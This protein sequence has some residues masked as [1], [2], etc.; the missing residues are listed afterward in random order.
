MTHRSP[1]PT[2]RLETNAIVLPSGDQTT[3][4]SSPGADARLRAAPPAAGTIQISNEPARSETKA[5]W[6]PSGENR[7]P[8]STCGLAAK[9]TGSPPATGRDQISGLPLRL[10][11]NRMVWLSGE[12]PAELTEYSSHA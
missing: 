10:L 8:T 4:L 12:S 1:P 11:S 3:R 7:G 5:T 2:S 9:G 6:L